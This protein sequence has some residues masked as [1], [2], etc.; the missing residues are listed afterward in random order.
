MGW[1]LEEGDLSLHKHVLD[2][3][4][5]IV[6]YKKIPIKDRIRDIVYSKRLKKI[7]MFLET[8]SSIAVLDNLN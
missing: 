6:S 5:N 3:D 1:N 7:F 4:F 8:S 2:E